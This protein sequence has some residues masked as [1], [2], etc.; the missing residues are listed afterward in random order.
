ME[1]FNVIEYNFNTNKVQAY[2]VIPYFVDTWNNK[3]HNF[4]KKDVNNKEDL[5]EWVIRTS[6]YMFRARCEYE[7]LIA[8]WPFGS[9]RKNDKLKEFLTKEFNI[10]DYS[11]RINFY[12]IITDDMEKIDVHQQIMMNIDVIVEILSNK[13]LNKSIK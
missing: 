3:K 1:E 10:D 11:Q 5:K 8:Q 12:N 2:N 4:N 9:K 6:S 7:C 13:F